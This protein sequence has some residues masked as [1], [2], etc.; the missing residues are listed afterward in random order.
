M[1]VQEL[2]RFDGVVLANTNLFED[3]ALMG[4]CFWGA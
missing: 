1:L 4:I 3:H 2:P